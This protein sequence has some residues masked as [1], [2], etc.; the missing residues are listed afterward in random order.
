MIGKLDVAVAEFPFGEMTC[1]E[2]SFT[3]RDERYRRLHEWPEPTY[4][5][6]SGLRMIWKYADVREVLDATTPGLSTANSLDPLVGFGR[7]A[8]TP[9][10]LPHVVRHLVPPPAEATANLT[11]DELHKRVWSTMAGPTGHFT[12]APGERPDRAAAMAEHFHAVR[13][14]L[15]RPHAGAYLD[16]TAVSIAYAAQ[17]VGA[18]VGLPPADWP[19]VAV[20]SGAQSGLLGRVMRGRELADAVR[21]LG[22]LFTVSSRAT[23]TGRGDEAT[24]F[25]RRLRDAGI[26][27]RIA[28]SAMANSLAAGVHTVSGTLQQGVQRLL[29]DPERKWWKL[30]AEPD[31][32]GRVAAKLLQLDPGLVAWKRQADTSVVLRSGTPLPAGPLLVMFGAANRDPAVFP[33]CLD[34]HGSGKLPLTFGFG[35]HICPGKSMA[36]LA[37]EVFLRQ[38]YELA[39]DAELLPPAG[40]T[41]ARRSDLLFS[42]ADITIR[43]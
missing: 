3:E 22:W 38:L 28:V 36:T 5:H 10:A 12:I 34:L 9:R 24:G 1:N 23:R 30:L 32:C 8:A 41:A 25:A 2:M 27:H 20:W 29:A 4:S 19:Q 15:H 7:I 16:V 11:D 35:R 14:S 31:G 17:T 37:V 40:H 21:A 33:D 43:W 18:A 26:S 6:P 13:D 39:P 42:G